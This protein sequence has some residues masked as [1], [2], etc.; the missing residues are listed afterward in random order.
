MSKLV[1]SF[2]LGFI[3]CG[4]IIMIVMCCYSKTILAKDMINNEANTI[5]MMR[6]TAQKITPLTINDI[7]VKLLNLDEKITSTNKRF[8]DLYIL[9]GIIITLLIAINI[10]VFITVEN[11]VDRYFKEHFDE[12]EK[13][14]VTSEKEAGTLLGK[15]R[16]YH[17]SLPTTQQNAQQQT[18]QP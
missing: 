13:N 15:I 6:D 18:Q 5:K 1:L 7:K 4:F 12:H 16:L 9:G 3:A 8:D 17:E 10:G 2:I 14:I 11:K